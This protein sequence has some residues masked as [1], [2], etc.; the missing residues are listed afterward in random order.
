MI[1]FYAK[2][3][4]RNHRGPTLM[5]SP[6]E[7]KDIFLEPICPNSY[8]S[9]QSHLLGKNYF[10]QSVVSSRTLPTTE[11]SSNSMGLSFKSWLFCI[12]HLP[13]QES[14]RSVEVLHN[15]A[16]YFRY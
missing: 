2:Q 5:K 8:I 6:I 7:V 10:S 1:G 11:L 12:Q 14:L 16:F 3:P 9:Y 13:Y 4:M 15:K